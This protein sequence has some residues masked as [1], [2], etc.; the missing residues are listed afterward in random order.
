[1]CAH[2]VVHDGQGE[3]RHF[4][5]LARDPKRPHRLEKIC[6]SEIAAGAHDCLQNEAHHVDQPVLDVLHAGRERAGR[7]HEARCPG[8]M[9]ES[10]FLN[11]PV[12]YLGRSGRELD[13]LVKPY[14]CFE[15]SP[16]QSL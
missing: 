13:V 10:Y 5:A 15:C 12:R 11:I 2:L 7:V 1:M 3:R 6:E 16:P 14:T 9:G 8:A 4:E